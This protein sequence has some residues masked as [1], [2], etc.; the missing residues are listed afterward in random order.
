MDDTLSEMMRAIFLFASLLFALPAL[1]AEKGTSTAQGVNEQMA[2]AQAMRSVPNGATVV[3][4]T[5]KEFGCWCIYLSIPMHGA[6]GSI[7]GATPE[8]LARPFLIP[9]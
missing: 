9:A 3:D 4:T 1:A 5:C 2:T 8:Q 7:I 6:L